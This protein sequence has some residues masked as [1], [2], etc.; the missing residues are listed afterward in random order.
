M[1]DAWPELPEAIRT[2]RALHALLIQRRLPYRLSR[3]KD[4]LLRSLGLC[5]KTVHV[6]GLR[7]R[8]RRLR[9]LAR[10]IYRVAEPLW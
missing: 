3:L 1:V 10:I 2:S 5:R 6:A 8:V 7:L 4:H 9:Q